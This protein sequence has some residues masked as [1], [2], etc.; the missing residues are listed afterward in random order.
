MK[1]IETTAKPYKGKAIYQ[2][3]GKAGEYAEY[4]C[5]FFIGCSNNCSYCYMKKGVFAHTWS[6]T[7]KL[8]ACFKKNESHALDCFAKEVLANLPELQKHG[9]FFSFTTDPML[10]KTFWFMKSVFVYYKFKIPIIIL[11]KRT[12]WVNHYIEECTR[13]RARMRKYLHFGFTL[14]GHDEMEPGANTNYERIEA[15][16]RLCIDGYKVWAS[17]EPIIDFESSLHMIRLSVPYCSHYKIGL[18]SGRKYDKAELNNFITKAVLAVGENPLA[19][20]YFKDSLLH[21]AGI[22]RKN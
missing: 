3:C 10:N 19:T 11:T 17:I 8:K 2:P 22:D 14:T 12:D 9:L 13:S 4:A 1:K 21:Q 6:D 20:I 15:I 16:K 7:P 18:E 5:N